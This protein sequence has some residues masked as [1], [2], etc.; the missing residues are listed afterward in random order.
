MLMLRFFLEGMEGWVVE[1]EG[2]AVVISCNPIWSGF[3]MLQGKS[4]LQRQEEI[5]KHQGRM[6]MLRDTLNKLV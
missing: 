6:R 5:R 3:G 1:G 4:S 2:S